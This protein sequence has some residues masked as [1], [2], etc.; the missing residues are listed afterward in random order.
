MP[1]CMNSPHRA[2]ASNM[3]SNTSFLDSQVG[4]IVHRLPSLG[5][6]SS[7]FPILRPR[8]AASLSIAPIGD[9]LGDNPKKSFGEYQVTASNQVLRRPSQPETSCVRAPDLNQYKAKAL[10]C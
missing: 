10:F 7:G 5:S 6:V 4:G 1:D 3:S 2:T 9:E 8:F